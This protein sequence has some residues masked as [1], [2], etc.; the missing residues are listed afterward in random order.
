MRYAVYVYDKFEGEREYDEKPVLPNKPH[1]KF[2]SI[3]RV[4]PE[5]DE[6]KQV[7]EGPTIEEDHANQVRRYVWTVRAKTTEEVGAE[8]ALKIDALDLV[9]FEI[10]F[11]N[12]NRLR[13]LEGKRA[14]TAAQFKAAIKGML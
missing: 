2:Y 13:A 9:S 3:E 14:I 8:K 1:I 4:D 7:K 11:R 5:Y 12:E 10:H 6:T